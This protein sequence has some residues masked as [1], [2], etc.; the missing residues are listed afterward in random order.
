MQTNSA[1]Q[2]YFD[3]YRLCLA[4]FSLLIIHM[5]GKMCQ[6]KEKHHEDKSH[7]LSNIHSTSPILTAVI[8]K[9]TSLPY[10]EA[11]KNTLL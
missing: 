7:H 4:T 5:L 8:V 1:Q 6:F 3:N 11:K 9:S 10:I 2:T